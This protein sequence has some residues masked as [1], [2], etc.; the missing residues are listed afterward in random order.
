MTRI[1]AERIRL[2]RSGGCFNYIDSR[3]DNA[4]REIFSCREEF[5]RILSTEAADQMK[6]QLSWR[7]ILLHLDVLFELL[8]EEVKELPGND[9][10]PGRIGDAAIRM[11]ERLLK[12]SGAEV[13]EAAPLLSESEQRISEHFISGQTEFLSRFHEL[14]GLISEKLF[15]GKP[16]TVIHSLHHWGDSRWQGRV[17]VGVETDAGTCYYKPRDCGIDAFYC[18]LVK[19]WFS[20]AL[21]APSV[22]LGNG[23]GFCSEIVSNPVTKPQDAALFVRNLGILLAVFSCLNGNDLKSCNI[24][25]CGTFPAAIDVETLFKPYLN[26]SELRSFTKAE[27]FI[28]SSA[29]YT[30]LFQLDFEK[31]E[32]AAL[33]NGYGIPP[34]TLSAADTEELLIRG[35][36]EGYFRI[37]RIR[38]ELSEDIK[39]RGEMMLRVLIGNTRRNLRI[40]ERTREAPCLKYFEKREKLFAYPPHSYYGMEPEAKEKLLRYDT[41]CFLEGEVPLYSARIRGRALY[42]RDHTDLIA[43]EMLVQSPLDHLQE[44]LS[45]MSPEECASNEELIRRASGLEA[46]HTA[47]ERESDCT[48]EIYIDLMKNALRAPEGTLWWYSISSLREND[49]KICLCFLQADAAVYCSALLYM[50]KPDTDGAFKD[51]TDV[52]DACLTAI[53]D[54]ISQWETVDAGLELPAGLHQGL[55]GLLLDLALMERLGCTDARGITDRLIMLLAKDNTYSDAHSGLMNGVAGLLSALCMLPVRREPEAEN[56]RLNHVRAAADTLINTLR[57][58]E[59]KNSLIRNP[60]P[61][62]GSTGAGTALLLAAEVLKAKQEAAEYA[63]S[64][65]RLLTKTREERYAEETGLCAA[66]AICFCRSL[67]DSAHPLQQCLDWAAG[68]AARHTEPATDDTLFHGNALRALFWQLAGKV[69]D[70]LAYRKKAAEITEEIQSIRMRDR[71][72][73][74]ASL[75]RGDLG[76]GLA[77]ILIRYEASLMKPERI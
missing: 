63:D 65:I 38:R 67:T 49:R 20:D 61:F 4:M 70:R 34:D 42:G 29:I 62:Y 12:S 60:D 1:E 76:T 10:S 53:E 58:T 45:R 5:R 31:R 77:V 22:V 24:I 17:T 57:Q 19:T 6:R 15:D 36:R 28:W 11:G 33:L 68:A 74:D 27:Q 39:N 43:E 55:G 18:H 16:V 8:V 32:S 54:K 35:F 72:P 64:G 41:A 73:F 23:Y 9:V 13:Y 69:T 75:L 50:G 2:L 48:R 40:L 26:N 66:V 3:A 47:P 37:L 25:P 51:A 44:R 7:L 71:R 21:E 59:K 52:R 46:K 30:G 14:R 56:L